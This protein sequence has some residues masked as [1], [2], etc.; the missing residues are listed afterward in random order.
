MK[1]LLALSVLFLVILFPKTATA[2]HIVGGEIYYDSLGNNQ[3]KITIE[4]FRDCMG[5]GAQFDTPLQYSVFYQNGTLYSEYS[6]FLAHQQVLPIVYD[7][8]CVTPPNNI[9]IERGTYI[10]T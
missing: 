9:C 4:I 3:Y 2:T 6:V 5:A 8:P 1:K 10:D 7:D